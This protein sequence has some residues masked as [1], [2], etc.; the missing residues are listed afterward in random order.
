[1]SSGRNPKVGNLAL[2]QHVGQQRVVFQNLF[3]MLRDL[4]DRVNSH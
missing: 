3:Y 1:V 4:A 2:Q